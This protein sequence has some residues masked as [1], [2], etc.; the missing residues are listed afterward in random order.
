MSKHK[1]RNKQRD[2]IPIE[3]YQ[4]QKEK[5]LGYT[6]QQ[7]FNFDANIL[8]DKKEKTKKIIKEETK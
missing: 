5:E 1:R 4:K 7:M 2:V 3:E 8:E 6:R